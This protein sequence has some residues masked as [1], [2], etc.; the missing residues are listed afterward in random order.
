[1]TVSLTPL[2]PDPAKSHKGHNFTHGLD[3]L[4]DGKFRFEIHAWPSGSFSVWRTIHGR[5]AP[6]QRISRSVWSHE[7]LFACYP[8]LRPHR[9]A[10][11]AALIQSLSS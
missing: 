6:L 3:V 7:E 2:S 1:M 5:P 8:R 10:I 11:T 9:E 4:I